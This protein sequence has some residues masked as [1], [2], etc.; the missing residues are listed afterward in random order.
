MCLEIVQCSPCR[1]S[2]NRQGIMFNFVD[3]KSMS[4]GDYGELHGSYASYALLFQ[5]QLSL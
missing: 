1:V 2:S 5:R 4:I 3:D